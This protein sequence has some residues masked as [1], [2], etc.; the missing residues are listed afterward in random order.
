[1]D[2]RTLVTACRYVCLQCISLLEAFVVSVSRKLE[3]EMFCLTT[4]LI[5]KV[6]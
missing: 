5:A 4:L 2:V 6:I 3:R 1:M